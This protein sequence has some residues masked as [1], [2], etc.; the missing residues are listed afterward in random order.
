MGNG[1]VTCAS[2]YSSDFNGDYGDGPGAAIWIDNLGTACPYYCY[3][4]IDSV[5][6]GLHVNC[7]LFV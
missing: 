3:Y 2:I 6:L 4:C 5:F 1:V 7:T